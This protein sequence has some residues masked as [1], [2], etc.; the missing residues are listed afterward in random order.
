[1]EKFDV[2]L[3]PPLP[4]PRYDRKRRETIGGGAVVFFN[5]LLFA[6]ITHGIALE[7]LAGIEHHGRTWWVFFSL[8]YGL[9]FIALLCLLILLVV[10]PGVVRRS[11]KT[12]FPIPTQMQPA[13]RDY[14]EHQGESHNQLFS[15]SESYY[16]AVDGTGDTYCVRCLVWRRQDNGRHY[17]CNTCQRCVKRYDHHCSVFGRCIAGKMFQWGGN[18]KYFVIIFCSFVAGFTT[19]FIALVWSLSL[20]FGPQWVLPISIFLVIYLILSS[21]ALIIGPQA[22]CQPCRETAVCVAEKCRANSR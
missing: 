10:D 2:S 7:A 14:L 16:T 5:I 21:R 8:I 17:H 1:M 4:T 9:A 12:C 11:A 20:L 18:Y 6:G 13:I 22:L 3:L 15:P 19:S